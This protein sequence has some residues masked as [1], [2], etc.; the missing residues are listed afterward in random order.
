MT[1][2]LEVSGLTKSFDDFTAVAGVD[3]ELPEGGIT[4]VIGPNGAGKTTFINLLAGKL[5]PDRGRITFAGADVTRLPPSARVRAGIARTFQVTNVF[6]RLTVEQNV[7]VPVLAHVGR[8][9][10][11]WQRLDSATVLHEQV[12][13]LLRSVGLAARAGDDAAVLSHGDRRLLE[14]ALALA[15]EPR[16]LLLDEPTA[17]MGAGERDRVLAQVRALAARRSPTIVLVEHDMEVVF[18]LAGRI[19]VLH[20]GKVIADGAPQRIRDDA[21]VREIYLGDATAAPPIPTADSEVGPPLLSVEHLDAGY[22]LAHVL[23]D[24]SFTVRRGEIVA[25]LGRNGMGKTTTLRSVAGLNTPWRGSAVTVAGQPI[26][27]APP[28]RIA[29]LGVSYVPDDRRIFADLTAA[30]NLRVADL[31]L[32][33]KA[34]RWSRPRIETVFPPL[35]RLW[36]RKGRHLSGGEQKMLAIARALTTDPSLLLLDEPSEGLGP[37]IVRILAEALAQIRGEGITVLLADQNLMFARAVADRALVMERG[38]VVH[39]ASRADLASNDPALHR[40]LVV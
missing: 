29:A 13:A 4:A 18:G 11:P 31:A 26:A 12:R 8:A 10:R 23:H 25:L 35:A 9:L 28:E 14:I 30:E 16:L 36:N 27:G 32:H 1:A 21:R 38:R 6:P 34:N 39:S 5:I 15:C 40:L 33:R 7:A 20:Q 2:L 24:V 19:V 37:Q 3:L 22:G 17:G